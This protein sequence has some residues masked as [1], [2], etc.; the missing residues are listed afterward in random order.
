M[1]LTYSLRRRLLLEL[2]RHPFGIAVI[3][4][5]S[6]C[7][8]VPNKKAKLPLS[9]THP[10]LAKEAFEWDPSTITKGSEKK[11]RWQCYRGHIYI[12]AVDKRAIRNQGCPFCSNK[13]LLLGFNDLATTNPEIALEADRWDAR[14]LVSGSTMRKKWICRYGHKWN[15]VIRERVRKN[16]G[17]PI[18]ANHKIL[19]GFND[20]KTTHPEIAQEAHGWNPSTVVAGSERKRK[21]KCP[22]DHIY[23]ANIR[24]R[25][26]VNSGC[27]YCSNHKVLKG[28][29]DLKTTHPEVAREAYIWNPSTVVA[30]FNKKR[31]WKCSEGHT[32]A[33]TPSS[34]T[35]R[36]DGCPSCAKYGFDPYENGY[37]YFLKHSDWQMLQIG[38]SNYPEKR[39]T[40]HKKLGWEVIEIRGPIEG[41][42]TQQWEKSILRMLKAKG[43]DLSNSKV[44]G[45]FDGYSEAWSKSTFPV[46]SIKELM[47]LTEEFEENK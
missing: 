30:G 7:Y 19:V 15:A 9:K 18:C 11:C 40:I 3:S 6:Y 24:D 27:P 1:V 4:A 32:W 26:R 16:L 17:C 2:L 28:F 14:T 47:R 23:I 10:K 22:K 37:L 31:R 13:K 35:S 25:T 12:A 36:G 8:T 42:L 21:W 34:R 39:I 20:L 41:H 46:K 44:A 38:I 45:K 33:S 5:L 29:N 43:A